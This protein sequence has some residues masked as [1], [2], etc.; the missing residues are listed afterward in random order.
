MN[1]TP[2]LIGPE[3]ESRLDWLALTDALAAGHARPRAEV[4]DTFLYRG[5]DTL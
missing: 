5:K 1:T 3:A 4:A 2:L